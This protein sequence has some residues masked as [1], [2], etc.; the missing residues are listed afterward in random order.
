[1]YTYAAKVWDSSIVQGA[2]SSVTGVCPYSSAER[3]SAGGAGTQ[4][5][6]DHRALAHVAAEAHRGAARVLGVGVLADADGGSCGVADGVAVRLAVPAPRVHAPAAAG[7][8]AAVHAS[9]AALQH[10]V[11]PAGVVH[12]A[13][14]RAVLHALQ[15][16]AFAG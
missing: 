5:A 14:A 15:E 11:P 1:M 4:A 7:A 13:G 16:G 12:A 3:C 9:V 8:V 10:R 6:G 2:I